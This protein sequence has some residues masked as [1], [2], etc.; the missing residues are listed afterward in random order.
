MTKK[1]FHVSLNYSN[2][3]ILLLKFML[4]FS[5]GFKIKIKLGGVYFDC[6][7]EDDE[8]QDA[9]FV[10]LVLHIA[11]LMMIMQLKNFLEK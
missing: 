6:F 1:L 10:D 4:L 8:I 11:F 2:L 9:D 3:G 7:V 5:H